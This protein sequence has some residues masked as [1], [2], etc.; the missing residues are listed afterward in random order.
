MRGRCRDGQ[1]RPAIRSHRFIVCSALS[2]GGPKMAKKNVT[3]KSAVQWI[4]IAKIKP[5]PAQRE[6]LNESRVARI[7][8]QFN[9]DFL[10]TPIVSARRGVFYV[11]DGMHR[12]EA[13]R[14]W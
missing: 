6:K 3:G 11:V 13:F 9:P 1:R 14:Q 4:S 12:I 5:A 7:L 8:S 2:G 10:G